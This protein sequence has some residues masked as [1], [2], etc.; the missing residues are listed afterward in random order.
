MTTPRAAS[1]EVAEGGLSI[2][3]PSSAGWNVSIKEKR[4]LINSVFTDTGKPCTRERQKPEA[5]A[6]ALWGERQG[7]VKS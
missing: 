5:A 7:G 6:H 2:T 1:Q 4:F 3:P